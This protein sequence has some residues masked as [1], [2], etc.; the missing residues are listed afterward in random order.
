MCWAWLLYATI[1]AI[2]GRI[3]RTARPGRRRL[4]VPWELSEPSG[5]TN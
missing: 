4:P 2:T 3:R 1:A 5:V